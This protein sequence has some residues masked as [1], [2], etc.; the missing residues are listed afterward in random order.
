MGFKPVE[1]E[2]RLSKNSKGITKTLLI[3]LL[4]LQQLLAT[5]E[6]SCWFLALHPLA[7]LGDAKVCEF[8][9]PEQSI[10]LEPEIDP[11]F[12]NLKLSKCP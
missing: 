9:L 5:A 12:G 10:P 7:G 11:K 3:Q 1:D 8:H 4:H 6:P 2:I